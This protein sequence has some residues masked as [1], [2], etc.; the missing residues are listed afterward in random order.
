MPIRDRVEKD[1]VKSKAEKLGHHLGRFL[2]VPLEPGVQ[3]HTRSECSKCNAS[4]N[5]IYIK[6]GWQHTGS[7]L[8][9]KCIRYRAP[10]PTEYIANLVMAMLTRPEMY[11]QNP[12]SLEDQT[13]TLIRLYLI[14][15][16]QPETREFDLYSK[17]LIQVTNQS[18][19]PSFRDRQIRSTLC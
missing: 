17:F 16:G 8:T 1:A 19:S 18:Q 12:A 10:K 7:A 2:S 11:V 6:Y 4:A 9:Q 3:Y 14:V 5:L 13:R 15:S